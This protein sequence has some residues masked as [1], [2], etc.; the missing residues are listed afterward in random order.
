MAHGRPMSEQCLILNGDTP[1]LTRET[2][3][4]LLEKHDHDQATL[5][6]LTVRMDNP[7]G[8]GRVVRGFDDHVTKVVEDRDSTPQEKAIQ[9][10]NVGSQITVKR[11]PL[12]AF[13][14]IPHK[15]FPKCLALEGP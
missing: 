7:K 8:Y 14:N 4:Q 13:F 3:Q 5:S 1:L 6:M 9:E 11:T 10:V 2:V 12:A 15:T